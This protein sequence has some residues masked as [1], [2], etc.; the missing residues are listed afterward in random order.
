MQVQISAGLP[1]TLP[2][3]QHLVSVDQNQEVTLKPL[4]LSPI[5]SYLTM[6]C[7]MAYSHNYTSFKIKAVSKSGFHLSVVK[8]IRTRSKDR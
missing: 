3:L 4:A 7:D 1:I 2:V 5:P 6:C 8:P